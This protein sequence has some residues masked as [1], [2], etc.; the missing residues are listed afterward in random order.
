M[1]GSSGV[2]PEKPEAERESENERQREKEDRERG[3]V[4]V[5]VREMTFRFVGCNPM[6]LSTAG[7][8]LAGGCAMCQ[9]CEKET[10]MV[11]CSSDLGNIFGCVFLLVDGPLFGLFL[12]GTHKDISVWGPYRGPSTGVFVKMLRADFPPEGDTGYFYAKSCRSR[13]AKP[14]HTISHGNQ[15]A[16]ARLRHWKFNVP[17]GIVKT[18]VEG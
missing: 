16:P 18:R 1:A 13:L 15:I 7:T 9:M 17:R 10:A 12:N 5:R 8:P 3:R 4:R 11:A 6:A 2:P 14:S